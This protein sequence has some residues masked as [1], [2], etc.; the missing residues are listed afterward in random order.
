VA[1]HL[2]SQMGI[3]SKVNRAV[4]PSISEHSS[5]Y[6][7]GRGEPFFLDVR[8][9]GARGDGRTDDTDAFQRTLDTAGDAGGGIVCASAAS[10]LLKGSIHVPGGVSLQGSF[11]CVPSHPG[12]RYAR[13]VK[14]GEDGTTLLAIGGR[15]NEDGSPLIS[16]SSNSSVRGLLIYYPEQR[17]DSEPTPYPWTIR[18]GGVN[19]EVCDVELLNPYQGISAVG[20]P[21]HYIRNVT[22][23]PLRRGI[24][25]DAIYDI[26][27]I[28]NVHFNPWWSMNTPVYRW[29]FLRGEAFVFGHA[30]WE[31]L[32]NTF[33]YGYSVG[34]RFIETRAGRCNGNFLGIAADDCNRAVLVES[35][36][37]FGLLITNGEFTAFRGNDPTAV[38]V[39]STNEGAVR[40][41]NSSFWGPGNQVA[42]IFGEG[43]VAFTDCTYDEWAHTNDRAAIQAASGSLLIRGCE[44]RQDS[45]HIWI[46]KKVSRAVVM[47]NIFAGVPKIENHSGGEV[48]VGLNAE[49]V[50]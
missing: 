31:F 14:P 9:F 17:T 42:K 16:L 23:Q 40:F 19:C 38:E 12:I 11:G 46:G 33:A 8:N 35:S 21:R 2:G 32:F 30:D 47:G 6:D 7:A 34:Y 4:P 29:Q 15:G 48:E 10:F 37:P 26:G 20:A 27:R 49:G 5:I 18:M 28:E 50:A 39:T 25:V 45:P 43:V 3:A 1:P 22:G 41:T 13:Q 44:F 24:F 36:A